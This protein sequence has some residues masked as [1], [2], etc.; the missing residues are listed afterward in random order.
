[1]P[2]R[3]FLPIEVEDLHLSQPELKA[4]A[5]Y[6]SNGYDGLAACIAAG[7]ISD[8]DSVAMQKLKAREF[9]NRPEC[10]QA[11]DRMTQS[12][13][14]PYWPRMEASLIQIEITRATYDIAWYYDDLGE[15]IPLS[16][17]PPERRAAIDNVEKKRYGKDGDEYTVAYMLCNR[18][19]AKKTLRELMAKSTGKTTD[20]TA[21]KR[22]E[23]QELFSAFTDG[24]TKLFSVAMQKKLDEQKQGLIE[25]TRPGVKATDII[26]KQAKHE[27][28]IP[29]G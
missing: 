15:P 8:R 1:M 23:L 17:I 26:T 6:C 18:D 10:I 9:F 27:I 16:S 21:E 25:A 24:A 7:L 29:K 3:K 13:L 28:R 12:I 14:A 5:E 2:K 19:A 22:K 11:V 4:I 20:A